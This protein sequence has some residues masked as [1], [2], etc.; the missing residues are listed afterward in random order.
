MALEVAAYYIPQYHSD[1]RNDAWHGKGWTEWDLVRAA[2]PRFPGHRQPIEPAWA[3]FD[4]ADPHWAAREIDAAADYGITTFIYNTYWHD[5]GHFLL[6]ALEHGFLEA[7]NVARMKFAILWA[8]NNWLNM[9]PARLSGVPELLAKGAVTRQ[10]F[11]A[12]VEHVIRNY[13]FHPSYLKIDGAPYFSIFDL[14]TFVEGL[15][16]VEAAREALEHFHFRAEGAG[17][18]GVHIN[19]MLWGGSRFE[20]HGGAAKLVSELGLDSVGA[21]NYTDHY[22]INK[23]AFPHGSYQKA[24]AANFA[25]WPTQEKTYGLPYIPNVTVGWDATPRCCLTDRF[26]QRDY[27]WVPVLEGSSPAAFRNGIER[28]K[29]FLSRPGVKVEMFT[30]NAWNAWTEGSYLLPDTHSGMAFLEAVKRGLVTR[31]L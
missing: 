11:D 26:E 13:F 23:D 1:P 7:A 31:H 3:H 9:H 24:A 25:A 16:S 27:P 18:K 17:L 29:Q 6:G 15:G 30:I 8:N 14:V 22:D 5:E 19:T 28:A 21:Y 20:K 2:R 4:Q 10:T 12:F